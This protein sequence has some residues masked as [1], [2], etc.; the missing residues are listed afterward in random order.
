M[1]AF[2]EVVLLEK[3]T[4]SDLLA[5]KG[6]LVGYCESSKA[7]YIYIL[8]QRWIEVWRMFPLRRW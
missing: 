2:A 5:R 6:T 8:G 4:M 3:R 1:V 7:Y